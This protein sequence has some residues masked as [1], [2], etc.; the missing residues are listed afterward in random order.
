MAAAMLVASLV[1]SWCFETIGRSR[2]QLAA[3]SWSWA[4]GI[5]GHIL[6]RRHEDRERAG[7][8]APSPPARLNPKPP[9][10]DAGRIDSVR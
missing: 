9:L 5:I 10:R 2:H 8:A 1:S 6:C 7:A 4:R 3:G